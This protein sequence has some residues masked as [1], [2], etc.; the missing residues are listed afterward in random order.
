[1]RREKWN[2]WCLECL[3]RRQI[4]QPFS[5]PALFHAVSCYLF[6]FSVWL[7]LGAA[8]RWEIVGQAKSNEDTQGLNEK[9]KKVLRKYLQN[10]LQT[11]M[12]GKGENSLKVKAVCLRRSL[13]RK[14]TLIPLMSW[15]VL[16]AV[17]LKKICKIVCKIRFWPSGRYL[18]GNCSTNFGIY[19]V[20]CQC[21][22]CKH[23]TV[24]CVQTSWWHS[25]LFWQFKCHEC[26]MINSRFREIVLYS[27]NS[28]LEAGW[29]LSVFYLPI[30]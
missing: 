8:I 12:A 28:K 17:P 29:R 1:M 24:Q 6:T 13:G 27:E 4:Q 14:T 3:V 23:Q 22:V 25:C 15:S 10:T 5:T 20:K 30:T 26:A 11:K 7:I 19:F 9:Q 2:L 16:S 21:L 18:G